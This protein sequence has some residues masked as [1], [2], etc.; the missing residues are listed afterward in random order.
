MFSFA[1][2]LLFLQSAPVVETQAYD[3][4]LEGAMHAQRFHSRNLWLNE[5]WKWLLDAFAD[6]YGVS[7]SYAKLR[8]LNVFW[9]PQ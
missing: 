4:L 2:F 3:L 1:P 9:I 5:P 7:N 8:Y 6:Y